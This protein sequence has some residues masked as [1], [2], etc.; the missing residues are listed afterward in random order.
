MVAPHLDTRLAEWSLAGIV[1]HEAKRFE[2][3]DLVSARIVIAAGWNWDQFAPFAVE[4]GIATEN[5]TGFADIATAKA[6]AL[7]KSADAL[8]AQIAAAQ[9]EGGAQ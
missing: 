8:R 1:R 3:S 9:K 7:V 6:S 5:A 4:N 2:P